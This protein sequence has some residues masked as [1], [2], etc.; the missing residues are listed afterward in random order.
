MSLEKYKAYKTSKTSGVVSRQVNNFTRQQILK[1][2]DILK[3]L[4]RMALYCARQ[5]IGLRGHRNEKLQISDDNHS[6][7]NSSV[8]ITTEIE[9][10]RNQ[11]NSFTISFFF[12][13]LQN[14][15]YIF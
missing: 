10:Y 12:F 1:N 11:G 14:Q 7:S 8:S 3:S 13:F 6:T 9:H 15:S 5:D 4:I 2:R